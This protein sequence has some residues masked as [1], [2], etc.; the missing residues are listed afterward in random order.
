MAWIDESALAGAVR[1]LPVNDA[2]R[3]VLLAAAAEAGVDALR[4]VSGGQPESGGGR[5][6]SHRHDGGGA[7]DL[8]LVVGRRTLD[9]TVPGDLAVIRRFIAAACSH[10]AT[11]VGAGVDYMGPTR[12]HVGFGNGPGDM[13]C[14]AWGAGGLAANAPAWLSDAARRGWSGESLAPG[15][16]EVVVGGEPTGVDHR[17]VEG[18]GL[19]GVIAAALRYSDRS[20]GL[21]GL[22]RKASILLIQVLFRLPATGAA[23]AATLPVLLRLAPAFRILG[24]LVAAFGVI[25]LVRNAG[26]LSLDSYLEAIDSFRGA[27]GAPAN[28]T[29]TELL[30]GLRQVLQAAKPTIESAV[31][32]P[33]WNEMLAAAAAILPRAAGSVFAIVFGIM[34][35]QFG[36]RIEQ[37]RL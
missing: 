29:W 1:N 20:D 21:F 14:V 5:V 37:G 9:F 18:G 17:P 6:G 4:I 31:R 23:D 19:K 22:A 33:P 12:L 25:G 36:A 24:F 3:Q 8:E 13:A 16:A 15:E 27:L 35:H 28:P 34:L 11:G 2:L 7:A 26:G 32:T 10:G 30:D